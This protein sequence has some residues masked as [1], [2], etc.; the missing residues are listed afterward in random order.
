MKHSVK[1]LVASGAVTAATLLGT[2]CIP[3]NL[4]TTPIPNGE[5]TDFDLTPS[6]PVIQSCLPNARAHVRVDT[7]VDVEGFDEF[8]ISAQGLV[9]N[10][11]YTVFLLETPVS[12]FGAAEYIGDFTTDAQGKAFNEFKLIVAEAFSST[13]V[14]GARVRTELNHVGFWFA[15]P[16]DDDKCFAPGTGAVTPFDGDNEAGVQVMNSSNVLPDFPLP[17]P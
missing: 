9:P 14:N 15:D 11:S 5:R 17:L 6:S 13:V 12:P 16:K 3:A 4:T 8:K 7:E 1:R 2:G 10:V